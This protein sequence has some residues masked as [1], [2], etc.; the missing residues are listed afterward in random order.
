[1]RTFAI[2]VLAALLS[3]GCAAPGPGNTVADGAPQDAE[4]WYRQGN[5]LAREDRLEEAR[6]AYVQALALD[7]DLARA[8]HNLGL[9]H[10]QL[11]WQ[12]LLQARRELPAD[13]R[14]AA[15]TMDYLG[16]LMQVLMGRPE[17]IHC[18]PPSGEETQQ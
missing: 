7:P 3:A 15:A 12:A 2:V 10:L 6:A 9:V 13:D 14:A 17:S 16:C 1:M 11:G 18:D 5:A 4:G 8:R